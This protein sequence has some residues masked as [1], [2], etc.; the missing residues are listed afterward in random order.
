VRTIHRLE[1]LRRGETLT[2]QV[3]GDGFL[4]GMVRNLVGTLVEV[5]RGRKTPAEVAALLAP[6]GTRRDAGPTMPAHGLEL[7][8]VSYPPELAPPEPG[9]GV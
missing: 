2:L 7:V 4:R 8:R 5:G 1:W 9:A 6:G 3:V